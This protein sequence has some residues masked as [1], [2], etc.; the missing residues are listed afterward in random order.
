[1]FPNGGPC[2][3]PPCSRHRPFG[4][5]GDWHMPPL[6]V[7]APQRFPRRMGGFF[8]AGTMLYMGS[9]FFM[10]LF[11]Y[12]GLFCCMAC[13]ESRGIPVLCSA[14]RKD[15]PAGHARS[16]E[17]AERP[18]GS[19]VNPIFCS[20]CTFCTAVTEQA[21]VDLPSTNRPPFRWRGSLPQP[22]KF[23]ELTKEI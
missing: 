21:R 6:R 17:S 8:C 19:L 5:A 23:N 13:F 16:A 9:C 18:G 20:F 7:F 3:H 1:L 14:H 4:M 11:L 2:D 12:M 22:P 10:R 15:L